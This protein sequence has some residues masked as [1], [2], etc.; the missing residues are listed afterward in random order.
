MTN[1]Y[2]SIVMVGRNDN[3]G[4]DF[5]YR[6]QNC[7]TWTIRNTE[8]FGIPAEIVFVNYNPVKENPAIPDIINLPEKLQFTTI[9]FI[10]VSE[11]VHE[12]F[13]DP[14][15]RRIVPLY[16]YIAKNIGIRRA[17][18]EFILSANPDILIHPK[19]FK[20]ISKRK[21]KMDSYYRCDRCD[22]SK[23]DIDFNQSD[24]KILAKLDQHT[25]KFVIKGLNHKRKSIKEKLRLIRVKTSFSNFKNRNMIRIEKIANYFSWP[26]IYDYL[27]MKYHTN[28]SGDFMLIHKSHWFD[29]HGYPENTY[30]AI[31]T[32]A[33]FV[34][35]A[36]SSGLKEVIFSKPAFHQDH[37][38][39]YKHDGDNEDE[40]IR[41][42]FE[43]MNI[44]GLKMDEAKK[45]I[46]YNDE[47][48]GCNQVPLEEKVY[49]C[50]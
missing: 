7:L 3:Y 32:D 5:N 11:V 18:G 39:R 27:P 29:L 28:C 14:K 48:W 45:P 17:K 9:R 30:L 44:E 46:I 16:E 8:K 24:E 19:I 15:K 49:P 42:M 50:Q 47:N 31:H 21:L 41:K 35:I 37:E 10:T 43:Y 1:P 33:L 38:R 25:F 22:F 26:V 34:I 20:I 12:R 23:F 36:A 6:L 40:D 2:L 4:I 13:S